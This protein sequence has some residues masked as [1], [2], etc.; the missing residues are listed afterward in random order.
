[1][2]ALSGHS[3]G[4]NSVS[5]SPD[6]ALLASGSCDKTVKLWNV[7]AKTVSSHSPL[8]TSHTFTVPSPEPDASRAPSGEKETEYTPSPCHESVFTQTPLL[9]FHTFN[10]LP[11]DPDA[12]RVPSGEEETK[13]TSLQ[14]PD[15][16]MCSAAWISSPERRSR[17]DDI[18]E[19]L[20]A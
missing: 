9:T 19:S 3:E 7:Y 13:C 5:F 17:G 10:V 14:C 8:L 18:H 16:F 15:S 11:T 12:R 2:K 4:V 6:G 1:V 20:R